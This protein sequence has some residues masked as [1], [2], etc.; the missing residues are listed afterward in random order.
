LPAF[1]PVT[2]K[3]TSEAEDQMWGDYNKYEA[4]FSAGN[5]ISEEDL[6][7]NTEREMDMMGIWDA[8]G[9]GRQLD[10]D[11]DRDM[12]NPEARDDA[13]LTELLEG[14][15]CS[16]ILFNYDPDPV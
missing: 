14:V 16:A 5:E 3:T 7:N 15:S 1:Q 2:E 4:G 6:R 13:L 10:A 9:L 11:L 8:V 12:K